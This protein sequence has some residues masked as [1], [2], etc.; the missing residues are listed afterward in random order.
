MIT[1]I[2]GQSFEGDQAEWRAN[3]FIVAQMTISKQ[4]R[5][6]RSI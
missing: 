6:R 2:L 4:E 3:G 1:D 5:A